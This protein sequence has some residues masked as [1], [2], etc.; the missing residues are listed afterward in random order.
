MAGIDFMAIASVE[1]I[2]TKGIQLLLTFLSIVPAVSMISIGLMAAIIEANTTRSWFIFRCFRI[3]TTLLAIVAWFI[4]TVNVDQ[5]IYP[6]V[7][8]LGS[9]GALIANLYLFAICI[10]FTVVPTSPL[11]LYQ[12]RRTA[13]VS[14]RVL[15]MLSFI[16]ATVLSMWVYY[17]IANVLIRVEP[18]HELPAGCQ[19]QH[20]I[21]WIGSR[22]IVVD[23]KNNTYVIRNE[24]PIRFRVLHP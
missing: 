8:V 24:A 11:T 9:F 19:E 4:W 18:A 10:F 6:A 17:T 5:W 1:D 23:C 3:I 21:R 22:S 16:M 14:W 2:V 13:V 20:R 12:I 7:T 15:T